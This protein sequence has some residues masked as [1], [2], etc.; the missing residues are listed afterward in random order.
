MTAN[1]TPLTTAAQVLAFA[2]IATKTKPRLTIS[3]WPDSCD[4]CR[5]QAGRHYC[6]LHE[7]K[8]RNMD[9][10]RCADH[11]DKGRGAQ[12]HG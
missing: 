12:P 3:R 2:G 10:R 11:A 8:A 9:A 1:D 6:L 7:I 5:H 4:T